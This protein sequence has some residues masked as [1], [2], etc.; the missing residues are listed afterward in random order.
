MAAPRTSTAVE[1]QGSL[2][3]YKILG[4]ENAPDFVIFFPFLELEQRV[5]HSFS[6][7]YWAGYVP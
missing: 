7:S 3:T 4:P 2:Q 6:N 1:T 5:D